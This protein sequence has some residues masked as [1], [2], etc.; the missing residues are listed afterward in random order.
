MRILASLGMWLT[1]RFGSVRPGE[2]VYVPPHIAKQKEP[3]YFCGVV[4]C[5]GHSTKADAAKFWTIEVETR[6]LPFSQHSLLVGRS[7]SDGSPDS[8]EAKP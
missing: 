1:R 4:F 7:E 8:T 6:P 3:P 5:P 2:E